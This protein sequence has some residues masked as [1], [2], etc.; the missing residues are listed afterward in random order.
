[1]RVWGVVLGRGVAW[2]MF[3]DEG[4]LGKEVISPQG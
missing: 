4:S 3:G 1:M 2:S